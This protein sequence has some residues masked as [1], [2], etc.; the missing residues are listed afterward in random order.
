MLAAAEL[1][2]DDDMVERVDTG[3]AKDV[4]DGKKDILNGGR[5]ADSKDSAY[6]VRRYLKFTRV[7]CIIFPASKQE[8]DDKSRRN[9]FRDNAGQCHTCDI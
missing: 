6:L 2:L 8:R 5:N 1:P 3:L 4:C 9:I 7:K